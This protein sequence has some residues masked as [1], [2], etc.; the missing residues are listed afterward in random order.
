M[1]N[2]SAMRKI[3]GTI[4]LVLL[5][6]ITRAQG[7]DRNKVMEYLQDQQYEEAI[8]Y[9]QPAV[10]SQSPREMALLAYTYYQSGKLADAAATYEKVLQLDS[11]HIPALQYLASI[12]SQ[13]EQFP[14]ALTLY[15][16][17]TRLRPNSAPAWKQLSFTAFLAQQ[18]DSGFTWLCKAYLLNPA[19]PKVVSRL[20]EEWIDK[21]AYPQADSIVKAFLIRD[22]TQSTVLMTAAKTAYLVKDYR[23][24]V[25]IGEKLQGLNIV[26]PNTFIYV[27]AASYNLK[28]YTDCIR[29]Y[30]YMLS[31]NAASENITY[32]AALAHTA[33]RQYSE[34][35]ELLQRCITMAKS[36]SLENYYNSTSVNYEGMRQYKPALAALDTSWYLSHKPLRQYSM[37]RIYETGLKNDAAAMKYYK[38]YLQLYKPGSTDEDEIYRYLRD[39]VKVKTLPALISVHQKDQQTAKQQP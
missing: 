8:A 22:S 18:P 25:S 4:G 29:I 14:L 13:Q 1:I 19:D 9:L 16:R 3:L 34:S 5:C 38:R 36:S 31:G 20:A 11:N 24:T 17:I 21:K 12:R 39:R 10:N 26:S 27:I 37:G 6:M 15:Q 30:D 35:N 23:R 2:L 33:L 32:Y 7:I 28:K